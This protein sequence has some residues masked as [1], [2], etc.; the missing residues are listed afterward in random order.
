ML[1]TNSTQVPRSVQICIWGL[2]GDDPDQL[3]TKWQ[4]MSKSAFSARR[5]G[6]VVQTNSTQSAKICPN[7]HF[8]GRGEVGEVRAN[9]P[10]ILECPHSSI[11]EQNFQTLRLATASQIVSHIRSMW[12]LIK[13]IQ[14]Y[15]YCPQT[16]FGAR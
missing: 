10:E 12:R 6:V 11:F 2:G 1:Q 5:R 8:W 9:I 3:N 13:Q 7:L 16:K 15:I 14:L 4:D